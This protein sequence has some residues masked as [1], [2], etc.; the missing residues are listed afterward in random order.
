MEQ[1]LTDL[2]LWLDGLGMWAY[3]AAPTVMA[4]VAVL[5]VPAEAPAMINGMLFGPLAGTAVTWTG[6]ML[7]AVVSFEIARAC[8]RPVAERLLKPSA[9]EKADEVVMKA[10]WWGL[11]AARFIPVVAFTAL[12]WGA[13]LTPVPRWRFIWTTAVGILPGA[14]LFTASGTG[15]S[16]LIRHASPLAAILAVAAAV[17]LLAWAYRKQRRPAH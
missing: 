10:G 16:F 7:G 6:A 5:P 13:G 15:V 4:A 12:N 11:L 3:L 2:T 14:V 8:G 1:L 17:A 9:L